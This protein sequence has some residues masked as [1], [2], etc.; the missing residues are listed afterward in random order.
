[1]PYETKQFTLKPLKE[2][3]PCLSWQEV[4]RHPKQP[5][6]SCLSSR[7]NYWLRAC[8]ASEAFAACLEVDFPASADQLTVLLDKIFSK[9][10]KHIRPQYLWRKFDTANRYANEASF[11][12]K[13]AKPL[14]DPF[15]LHRDAKHLL[16]LPGI[17][18]KRCPTN[19]KYAHQY[20][21]PDSY[22]V[23]FQ[24]AYAHLVQWKQATSV[25]AKVV[26]CA[27]MYQYMINARPFTQHNNSFFMV[28]INTLL[29]L[30]GVIGIS[31]YL[32]DHLAHRLLPENF[33][34]VFYTAFLFH[35]PPHQPTVIPQ[36]KKPNV[37]AYLWKILLLSINLPKDQGIKRIEQMLEKLDIADSQ[38]NYLY[39]VL[40]NSLQRK[41]T[42][43]ALIPT[44]EEDYS[45][46]AEWFSHLASLPGLYTRI[47]PLE[48]A[49]AS[50]FL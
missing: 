31:H 40:C 27:K 46:I 24:Q 13:V 3:E 22:P 33:C 9:F 4:V 44:Q 34:T 6:P 5:L 16:A 21:G 15:F 8:A 36:T 20:P 35:N 39:R 32:L 23:Y 10:S 28:L 42:P 43:F 38:A 29:R 14:W 37:Y 49:R 2:K 48:V 47:F 26:A 17:P 45:F 50:H 18:K 30:S 12:K 19:E 7:Y 41:L 11:C 1:M 25:S